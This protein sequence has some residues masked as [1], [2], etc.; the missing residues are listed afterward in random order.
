MVADLDCAGV[1]DLM[2]GLSA[3]VSEF[4]GAHQRGLHAFLTGIGPVVDMASVAQTQLD[5]VAATRFSVF[6]YFKENENILSAIFADLMRPNGTHGQGAKFLEHFLGQVDL[7]SWGKN[8][9]ARRDYGDLRQ[10]EVYTEYVIPVVGGTADDHDRRIDIVLRKAGYWIA[11]ENKPWADERKDQLRDYL[12][13]V[14]SRDCGSCVLYLNGKGE[15]SKIQ[16]DNWASYLM[17][18]YRSEGCGPSV[19]SWIDE[20]LKSCRADNVRWFLTDL[21]DYIDRTF[22]VPQSLRAEQNDD[23]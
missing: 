15:E 20:C 1:R 5:L 19:S 2:D 18:P 6:E 4:K 7:G 14:H 3:K 22:N 13:Y 21:R 17:M 9:R 8:I 16:P 11:I 12:A 23:E 10:F